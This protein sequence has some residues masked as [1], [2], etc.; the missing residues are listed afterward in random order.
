[1]GAPATC[2]VAM[3]TRSGEVS[4]TTQVFVQTCTCSGRDSR[5][6]QRGQ[7]T[8]LCQRLRGRNEAPGD[9]QV[10]PARVEQRHVCPHDREGPSFTEPE[11][12]S[13]AVKVQRITSKASKRSGHQAPA[14]HE[15]AYCARQPYP[16]RCQL[17]WHLRHS[18]TDFCRSRSTRLSQSDD[19]DHHRLSHLLKFPK[20]RI[21]AGEPV[22][23]KGW[24]PT[25]KMAYD[26]K[27]T[28]AA[29]P[30]TES[31]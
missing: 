27:N 1:M 10:W 17:D 23:Q 12:E 13:Q 26:T 25:W 30:Y 2:I 3:C 29:K 15:Q 9:R 4:R 19:D 6:R 20:A 28:P 5:W 14:N 7:D 22:R 21:G 18:R 8:H 24:G 11:Q 31:E 16:L